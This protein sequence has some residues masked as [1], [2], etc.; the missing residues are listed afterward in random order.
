MSEQANPYDL[1]IADLEAQRD[2]LNTAID[3]LKGLRKLGVSFAHLASGFAAPG[4]PQTPDVP[5]PST[6]PHDA[7]YGMTVI[8]AAKKYLGWGG[9]KQTRPHAELC[10][11]IREGGFQTNATNFREV[12][13]STL[14]R[15]P[16]FVKIKG[17]WG[18]KEWYVGRGV[19]S[20]R[21]RRSD[22]EGQ[23]EPE[24]EHTEAGS[25]E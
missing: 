16:D 8:D 1:V 13:R 21:Q 2:K 4:L 22:T 10:E 6:I 14:G 17:Q 18:L 5:G 25:T 9:S 24:R 23:P 11:A 3:A 19:G 20:R 7:F 15:H 12:V